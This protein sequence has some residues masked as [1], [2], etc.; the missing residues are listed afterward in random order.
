MD[1]AGY[2]IE[3]NWVEETVRPVVQAA[4][5]E[6]QID[7]V[8]ADFAKNR[9]V[10]VGRFVMPIVELPQEEASTKAFITELDAAIAK[11]HSEVFKG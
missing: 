9:G 8:L 1:M 2:K 11:A 6:G 10:L 3:A 7:T 4:H 5:D